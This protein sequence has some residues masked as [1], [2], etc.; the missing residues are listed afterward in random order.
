MSTFIVGNKPYQIFDIFILLKSFSGFKGALF[1]YKQR[2]RALD[3]INSSLE[4]R[5]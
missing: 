1:A 4:E 2:D 3:T 5:T